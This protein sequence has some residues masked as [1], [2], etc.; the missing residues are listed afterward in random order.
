MVDLTNISYGTKT[1]ISISTL[2]SPPLALHLPLPHRVDQPLGGW[3]SDH[4]D[5]SEKLFTVQKSR[6]R[7]FRCCN[8]IANKVNLYSSMTCYIGKVMYISA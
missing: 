5:L 1:P 6:S 4:P 7:L 2:I 3:P 8:D